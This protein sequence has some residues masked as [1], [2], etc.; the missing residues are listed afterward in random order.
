M[1]LPDMKEELAVEEFRQVCDEI[2]SEMTE[3]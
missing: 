3:L 2:R 1:K